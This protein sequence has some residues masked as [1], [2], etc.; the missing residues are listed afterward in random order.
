MQSIRKK[1]KNNALCLKHSQT[2]RGRRPRRPAFKILPFDTA[3]ILCFG[4]FVNRPYRKMKMSCVN[5][6][7]RDC[8]LSADDQTR[9]RGR[10][11]KMLLSKNSYIKDILMKRVLF[12]L[13]S[14]CLILCAASCKSEDGATDTDTKETR[15]PSLPTRQVSSPTDLLPRPTSLPTRH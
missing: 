15:L 9:K 7:F 2:C 13:L 6:S 5:L 3:V 14:V 10:L 4:R 12:I 1:S 8:R 11:Y